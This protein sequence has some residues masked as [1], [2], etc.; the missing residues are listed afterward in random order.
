VAVH[1]ISYSLHALVRGQPVNNETIV[2]KSIIKPKVRRDLLASAG[3]FASRS[4]VD[5]YLLL[6]L[7]DKDLI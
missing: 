5:F 4:E 2:D 7:R 3:R 1:K 6:K